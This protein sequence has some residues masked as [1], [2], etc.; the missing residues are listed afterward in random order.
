MKNCGAK[1][2]D[3]ISYEYTFSNNIKQVYEL[4]LHIPSL[5]FPQNF[6]QKFEIVEDSD[7]Q[8][9]KVRGPGADGLFKFKI[10]E[11]SKST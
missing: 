6:L 8:I 10:V 11:E 7:I 9:A 1:M 5:L 3:V 4:L 2:E